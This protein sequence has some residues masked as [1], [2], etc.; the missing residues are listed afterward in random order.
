MKALPL[1][2]AVV[3]VAAGLAGCIGADTADDVEPSSRPE[4]T[5]PTYAPEVGFQAPQ[6]EPHPAGDLP[7]VNE[8]LRGVTG[9]VPSWWTPPPEAEV[10]STVGGL[11]HVA[12]VEDDEEMGASIAVFG[13]LV[14]VPGIDEETSVY[15]IS[16]P[17]D[18]Q[19]LSELDPPHAH[20][21]EPLA[22]RDGRL[23]AVSATNAGPLLVHDLTD[24][25]NP[26]LVTRF[27]PKHG[28]A[29]NLALVPGTTLLYSAA[30]EGGGPGHAAPGQAS[31]TTAIYDLS[32][33][34]SPEF[35]Q[36]FENGYNCSY[37]SFH[38][39]QDRQRAYCG[40]I[41]A[42]QIWD[43]EDPR[44]PQVVATL[45]H[46]H[47]EPGAPG[48]GAIQGSW[49]HITIANHDA[50]LLVVADETGG[51][52]APACDAHAEPA[53]ES[54]SGP[55]SNLW[56]YDITDETNPQLVGW[57]SPDSHLVEDPPPHEYPGPLPVSA[58]AAHQGHLLPQE[59][60]LVIG[61]FGG[62]AVVVDFTDPSNPLILDEWTGAAVYEA[63]AY[64]GY[65]LTGDLQGMNVFTLKGDG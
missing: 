7:T 29:A 24:P 48:A 50:S 34:G 20:D 36:D 17:S 12:G 1:V 2:T 18:P 11:E 6:Y 43:V 53:G 39:T 60:H 30:G 25:T 21:V 16:D 19:L 47:G 38:I 55:S 41:E 32:D 4:A 58:C 46:P 56:F 15:D 5:V 33:P 61:Y 44:N 52:L 45:P 51:S 64:Q 28:T 3:L 27:E 54:V 57:V 10:P 35:V 63:W 8:P 31:G 14:V 65:V 23:F 26:E 13:S 42:A 49:A 59:D 40:G 37:V 22:F 62:G 9:D